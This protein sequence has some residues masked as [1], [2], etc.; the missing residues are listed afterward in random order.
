MTGF[1]QVLWLSFTGQKLLGDFKLGINDK[2]YRKKH[3]VNVW[4][5]EA[6]SLNQ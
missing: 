5:N 4:L 2:L 1:F 3:S 6:C